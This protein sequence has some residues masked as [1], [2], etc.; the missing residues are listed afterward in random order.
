MRFG[1]CHWDASSLTIRFFNVFFRVKVKF[2]ILLAIRESIVTVV[3]HLLECPF[4]NA[5]L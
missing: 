4:K 2:R 5:P 1:P 3:S